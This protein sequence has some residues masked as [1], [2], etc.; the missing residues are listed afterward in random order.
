M[1]DTR[2]NPPLV[3]VPANT[4]E[5]EA[6]HW[7][8]AADTYLQAI[9]HGIGGIP[10][11]VPYLSDEVDF[12]ALVARVD[13]VLLTGGRT[14]IH[15]ENYGAPADPRAEPHDPG[16][17]ALAFALARAALRHGVPLFAVCRGVQELNVALGGSL[18][19]EVQEI[20]GRHD[21]RA[22]KSEDRD[23]RFAIRQDVEIVPG[24]LLA[25]ILGAG[26]V[27]VNSLHRQAIDR[28]GEGLMV[29]ATAPDGTIEAVSVVGA[30]TF[31]LGVQ[32]HPEYW[33]RTDPPSTK[34][35][36]AF[37]AAIRKRMAEREPVP[38]AA[39]AAE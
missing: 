24:G 3:A 30:P 36:A 7:H 4:K 28:L 22:P 9:V 19:S 26:T 38:A 33:V 5:L 32:W 20:A 27:R 1:T 6:Y 13:G 31:A 15:P 35:F 18:H 39:Q 25:E 10:L 34:L 37:G 16:R 17:D 29:E 21:H 2:N 23:A 11:I 8:G 12:D 14:N